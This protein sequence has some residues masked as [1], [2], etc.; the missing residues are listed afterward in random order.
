MKTS[1]LLLAVPVL[2]LAHEALADDAPPAEPD[3]AA[4]IGVTV[5]AGPALFHRSSTSPTEESGFFLGGEVRVHPLPTHGFVLGY[6]RAAGIFG[7]RVSILDAAY[8]L[9]LVGPRRLQGVTGALYLDVGPSAGFAYVH[10]E[11][12][13]H[14]ILGGRLTVGGDLQITNFLVGAFVTYRGGIPIGAPDGWEG[15]LTC[16]LRLGLAFDV[17]QRR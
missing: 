7:P 2:L 4:R 12:P 10:S 15:V 3:P 11:D 14:A 17:G 16:G 9:Q 13:T 8:S 1:F 5:N 6:T